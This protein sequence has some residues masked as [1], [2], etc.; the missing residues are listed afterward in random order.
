M[1]RNLNKIILCIGTSDCIGD[2]LGPMVGE[3]LYNNINKS[4]IYIYGNLKNNITYKNINIILNK[5]NTQI[6]R[7]YIILVDSALSNK[8]YI[9]KIIVSKNKMVIGGALDK[10]NYQLG[11][12]SIKGIVG[13]NKYNCIEN[14]D[15]L[16][17][18]SMKLI[19]NYLVKYQIK[20]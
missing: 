14:Y 17:N 13:E 3:H 4:N 6:K 19:K 8:N 10:Q 9:G 12:L 18:V 5:L 2:S 11:D 1:N 20:Y 7:H 15:E 16:N